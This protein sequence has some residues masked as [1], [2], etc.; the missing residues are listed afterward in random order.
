M[1]KGKDLGDVIALGPPKEAA[2]YFDRVLPI[3]MAK[4]FMRPP[5]DPDFDLSI[6]YYDGKVSEDVVQ[7]LLPGYSNS[8]DAYVKLVL[9]SFASWI[10]KEITDNPEALES[11]IEMVPGTPFAEQ[12]EAM[13]VGIDELIGE[14]SEGRADAKAIIG[15]IVDTG[16]FP[17][18]EETRFSH[19]STWSPER[20]SVTSDSSESARLIATMRD[21]KLVDPAKASWK[22]VIEFRKDESSRRALRDLRLFFSENFEGKDPGYI[23]DK[24]DQLL[25]QHDKAAKSWGFSTKINA[26]SVLFTKESL[27]ATGAAALAVQLGLPA[28]VAGGAGAVFAIGRTSVEFAKVFVDAKKTQIDRPVRY[29][30]HL[31]QAFE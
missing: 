1:T 16:I 2:L 21:L 3:D 10:V 6:P 25:E 17:V 18:I 29:L 24:L 31:K 30:S 8:R 5:A 9:A 26:L 20:P 7:S 22:Q 11:F 28:L 19:S 12:M 15:R 13:G 4:G 14:A 27:M 23:A